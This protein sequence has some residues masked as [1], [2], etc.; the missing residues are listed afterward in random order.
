MKD[1]MIMAGIG[2]GYIIILPLAILGL[3]VL[4]VANI[5]AKIKGEL[6]IVK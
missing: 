5:V 3:L 4:F 2:V 1:N 6:W